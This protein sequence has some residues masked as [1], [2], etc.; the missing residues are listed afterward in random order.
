M[1]DPTKPT[2][3]AGEVPATVGLPPTDMPSTAQFGAPADAADEE[4][5]DPAEATSITV[6]ITTVGADPVTVHL[7]P[8]A[9][10]ADA[11]RLAEVPEGEYEFRIDNEKAERDSELED[12]DE[13]LYLQKVRGA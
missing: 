9:T 11:L 1:V 4:S 5:T 7:A 12:G 6:T 10:V 3:A 8:G 13:I 2:D